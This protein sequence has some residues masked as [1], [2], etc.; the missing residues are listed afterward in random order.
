MKNN[1][2]KQENSSQVWQKV[3]SQKNRRE[4]LSA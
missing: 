3:G 1:F 4:K 2:K